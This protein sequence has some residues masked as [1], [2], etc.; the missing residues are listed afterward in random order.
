MIP[1]PLIHTV[2]AGWLGLVSL[3]VFPSPAADDPDSQRIEKLIAQLGS[4]DFH[5]REEASLAL[6]A[7]GASALEALRQAAKST[8]PEVRQRAE[9]LVQKITHQIESAKLLTPL[10]IH[11]KYQD[12]PVDQAVKDLAKQS[13]YSIAL[14]GGKGKL[15]GRRVTLSTGET[16]FWEAFDQF[17]RKAGLVEEKPAPPK[18]GMGFKG[19]G[20]PGF[21]GPGGAPPPFPGKVPPGFP[22]PGG[23]PPP[24][25]GQLPP[26]GFPPGGGALPLPGA[27]P[28]LLDAGTGKLVLVD[29]KPPRL[30]T[31]YAGAMRI[32]ALP[33]STT[34]AGTIQVTLE[35]TPEPRMQWRNRGSSHI[36]QAVDDRDQTL[37]EAAAP[38]AGPGMPGL[39]FMPANTRHFNVRLQAAD[40]PSKSLKMLKGTVSGDVQIPLGELV[41]VKN[42]LQAAGQT[43]KGKDGTSLEVLHASRQKDGSIRVQVKLTTPAD[44]IPVVTDQDKGTFPGQ[45]PPGLG[46]PQPPRGMPLPNLTGL[47]LLDDKGR[48]LPLVDNNHSENKAGNSIIREATLA[49]QP[50]QGQGNAVKFRFTGARVAPI[51]VP[52][53]LTDVPLR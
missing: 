16:T 39:A 13:G 24:V 41:E 38:A 30:P 49:F 23:A 42:I 6:K 22:P 53:T 28:V 18:G 17:C 7:V 48:S 2:L 44:I 21:P 34:S 9:D 19:A 32:R 26:P 8:D 14:A 3:P 20:P 37:A 12:T 36:D 4:S 52:F 27:I 40:N 1:Y 45:I 33:D 50:K 35:V 11:L 47:A 15:A 5:E 10:R 25:P 51:A 43:V 29:G 31:C 46:R